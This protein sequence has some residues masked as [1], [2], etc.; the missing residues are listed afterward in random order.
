MADSTND[1]EQVRAAFRLGWG[2]S[3]LRGRFRP[4]R[5]NDPVPVVPGHVDFKRPT[6]ELPL[7][8]ERSPDEVRIEILEA[9]GGLAALLGLESDTGVTQAIAQITE[10]AHELN[11]DG[12]DI[13]ARWQDIAERFYSLDAKLQDAL[14]V[15]GSQ[16]AA[17]QLG[18]GLADTYWALFTDRP[19]NEMG[20]W[21]NLLGPERYDTV[22]RQALRLSPEIGPLVLAAIGGPLDQWRQ[23]ALDSSRR[24]ADGAVAALYRQG[25]LW[26]DLIRGERQPSDLKQPRAREVWGDL[27]LYRAVFATLR[28]P[29]LLGLVAAAALV[30]GAALLA[31]HKAN[32][33]LSAA[34]SVIGALGITSASLYARAKAELTSLLATVHQTVQLE[35]V[36]RAANECPDP[37]AKS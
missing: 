3:E 15:R 13:D 7:A 2:L 36:R 20:S 11:Q 5:F 37:P 26:R 9:V 28:A 24:S 31:G 4:D 23:L 1:V 29:I 16:A 33:G 30:V 17:Y 34:I 35:R 19:Q 18:R 12:A 22:L 25:L 6:H 21:T 8:I 14:V 10:A 32:S 27:K